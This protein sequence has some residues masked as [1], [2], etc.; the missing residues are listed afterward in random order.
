MKR[1]KITQ[2]IDQLRK[3]MNNSMTAQLI[4]QYDDFDKQFLKNKLIETKQLA[5]D[6]KER[7][8]LIKNINAKE[9]NKL[10]QT[11]LDDDYLRFKQRE[12][13]A[14][15]S[16]L[17]MRLERPPAKFQTIVD[18]NAQRKRFGSDSSDDLSEIKENKNKTVNKVNNK[19]KTPV[20]VQ[21]E[22]EF[23][24]DDS[25][26]SEECEDVSIADPS[27]KVNTENYLLEEKPSQDTRLPGVENTKQEMHTRSESLENVPTLSNKESIDL[28]IVP[29]SKD[30]LNM[31]EN[32]KT[33]DLYTKGDEKEASLT[34]D[35]NR[36]KDGN[37]KEIEVSDENK[38]HDS[39]ET[40]PD[41]PLNESLREEAE[42]TDNDLLD[43]NTY[44]EDDSEVAGPSGVKTLSPSSDLQISQ[45]ESN[46]KVTTEKK[47]LESKQLSKVR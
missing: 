12:E 2:Q 39:E 16:D 6:E 32:D 24:S 19:A 17:F 31:V 34:I 7:Y 9:G 44:H 25:T 40:K 43:L 1:G 14:E 23:M 15:E 18:A 22:V 11:S 30:T 29:A 45:D 41:I 27:V 35:L 33:L 38:Q 4:E 13:T 26:T 42:T 21:D 3:D 37:V 28:K 5:S 8:I 20:I 36:S 46:L 10:F 47:D